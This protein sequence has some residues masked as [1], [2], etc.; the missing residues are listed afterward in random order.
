ML[1]P[2]KRTRHLLAAATLLTGT[3]F[4]HAQEPTPTPTSPAESQPETKPEPPAPP[5]GKVLFTRTLPTP[6]DTPDDP[7]TPPAQAVSSS[8]QTPIPGPPDSLPKTPIAE[9]ERASVLLTTLDLDVHLI[10][11]D[12]RL[13]SHATLTLRNTGPTPLTRIPLQISS[14][15]RWQSIS[16]VT[17]AGLAPAAFTQS[18]IATD[19]DH[20]GYAQEAVVSLA[21]PLAPD[22]TLT[23]SVFY[24]GEIRQSASRL[25][26]IGTPPARADQADWDEIAPTSDASATSLRGFG[27]VLWYPIATPTAVLG[28]GNKLVDL[29][30]RVRA[31]MAASSMHLR[32]AVEY[33]GEAPLGAFFNGALQTLTPAPD[34]EDE[35]VAQSHGVTT[36]DF[37]SRPIGFRIPSLFLTDQEPAVSEDQTLSVLTPTPGSIPAWTDAASAVRPLITDWFGV[38]PTAPL[39]LLDH[40]GDSYPDH[41]FLALQMDTKA[42]PADLV[43]PLTHAW[44]HSAHPWIDEGLAEFMSLLWL[45]RAK[46]REAA[47]AQ[48]AQQAT[49]IALAE[50]DLSAATSGAPAGEPLTAPISPIYFRLKSAAV[51]WQLRELLGEDTLRQA[52]IAYRHSQSQSSTF[53]TDPKA[54]QRTLERASNKDLNWFFKDWVYAD[55]SLPDLSIME[56]NPRAMPD[57]LGKD[58]GYLVAVEIRNEGDAAADVPVTVRSGTLTATERLRIPARSVASTRILFNGVPEA[59]QV[60]DGTVPELRTLTHTR[61]LQLRKPTP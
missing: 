3:A 55:R 51:W 59:V 31:S 1:Q 25:E 4:L 42:D 36:A 10:P 16:A 23:L 57:K 26:L 5:A 41:A 12:A 11:D 46:G 7:T 60:N 19:A 39:I 58:A 2:S 56:V 53:D 48:L 34:L 45:E 43:A 17:S 14:T 52:L 37:A 49:L 32:L 61:Q 40:P 30:S 44:I 29:I 28:D 13:E 21:E 18:P 6:A 24:L 33:T 22:K 47:L 27:N 9:S 50:P 35:L 20:T 38:N 15:L 8:L 54:M